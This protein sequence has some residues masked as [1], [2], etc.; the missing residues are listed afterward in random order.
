MKISP[1]GTPKT[2]QDWEFFKQ[3]MDLMSQ[4]GKENPLYLAAT[5]TYL[6][7]ISAISEIFR[8]SESDA[9]AKAVEELGYV[10]YAALTSQAASLPD[11]KGAT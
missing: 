6:R 3:D 8:E 7:G 5:L 11:E 4:F 9:T 2:E 10:M 1:L